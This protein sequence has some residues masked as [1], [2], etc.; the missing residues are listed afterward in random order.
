[1]S[2]EQK[3]IRP[4]VISTDCSSRLDELRRFRHLVRNLYTFN[5]VPE[6]LEPIVSDLPALW[7]EVQAEILA[8]ADFLEQT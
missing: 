1:M 6:K 2:K 4:A 7:Q 8:F 5:L 3:D